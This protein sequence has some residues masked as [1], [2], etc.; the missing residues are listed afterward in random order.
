M[1]LTNGTEYIWAVT[2]KLK[3]TL[4]V[5]FHVEFKDMRRISIY[6]KSQILGQA[7]ATEAASTLVSWALSS[8]ESVGFGL[9]AMPK[10]CLQLEF[11][12]SLG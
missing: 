3:T 12:K 2:I 8:R 4:S 9:R 11:W 7:Y 5:S 6:A 1:T 10:I